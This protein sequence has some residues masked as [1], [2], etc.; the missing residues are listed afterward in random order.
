MG[1]FLQNFSLLILFIWVPAII[2]II[3]LITNGNFDFDIFTIVSVLALLV[4]ALLTFLIGYLNGK[5]DENI[6]QSI[7]ERENFN[8]RF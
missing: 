4:L 2:I 7:E 8:P 5:H 6:N 3:G 1:T